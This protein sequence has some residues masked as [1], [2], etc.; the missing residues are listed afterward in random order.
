VSCS[1]AGNRSAGGEYTDASANGQAF[2]ANK[3]NGTWGT[4]KE[5][6][7]TSALNKGFDQLDSLSCVPAAA[8]NCGAGGLYT[9]ASGHVQ[10][11]VAGE[12]NGTWGAAKEV[13]GTA[14]L[15]QGG[16]A[17]LASVSCA[18]AGNCS[19]GGS[20][21]DVSGRTQVFVIGETNGVWNAAKEVPGTAALNSGGGAFI[22]SVSCG[23]VGNCGAGGE[24]RD[25]SHHQQAFVVN[26]TNGT[27]HSAIEVPG[28]AALNHGTAVTGSVSCASAGHCS[29][30][31]QYVDSSQ[32]VQAFVVNES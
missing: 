5:V 9:D 7:G 8:G 29:A 4:A 23:A 6:P 31:G 11:F 3:V 15:N 28:T 1:S 24:Y 19:A 30:E 14:A 21:T 32:H 26:E 10:A 16:S 12:T 20:Y 25:S 17:G 22:D 2:I 18:S 13:P 27:W